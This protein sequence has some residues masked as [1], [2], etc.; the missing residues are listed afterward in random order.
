VVLAAV[1]LLE[2]VVQH[3]LGGGLLVLESLVPFL[4]TSSVIFLTETWYLWK[5]K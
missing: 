3:V 4:L 1:L 2:D 5:G